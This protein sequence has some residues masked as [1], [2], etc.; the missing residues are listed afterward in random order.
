[1]A[2]GRLPEKKEDV[3][4][5][6]PDEGVDKPDEGGDKPDEGETTPPV[7]DSGSTQQV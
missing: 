4:P 7:E 6:K 1:M 3:D 2:V 5:D